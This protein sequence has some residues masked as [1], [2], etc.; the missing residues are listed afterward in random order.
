M[1]KTTRPGFASP[2]QL[3][4][5]F[6]VPFALA[7]DDAVFYGW[8]TDRGPVLIAQT[9]LQL[10]FILPPTDDLC[11]DS[12]EGRTG[13]ILLTLRDVVALPYDVCAPGALV[14]EEIRG[15]TWVH[16]AFSEIKGWADAIQAVSD[17]SRVI[18][19]IAKVVNVP[20]TPQGGPGPP[21]RPRGRAQW[22]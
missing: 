21:P 1:Q 15:L 3:N 18:M 2:L 17:G 19:T 5:G 12:P 20:F 6:L 14:S 22:F 8:N 7:D 16:S 9:Q 10:T 13:L 11:E 4:H